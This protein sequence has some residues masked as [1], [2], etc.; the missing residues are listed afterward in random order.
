M[1]LIK[2]K[3]CG[4]TIS[5]AAKKCPNCGSEVES[6]IELRGNLICPECGEKINYITSSCTECG[7][8]FMVTPIRFRTFIMA[9]NPIQVGVEA[10]GQAGQIKA[11]LF[12]KGARG[13]YVYEG[14]FAC[15]FSALRFYVHELGDLKIRSVELTVRC[16]N[17]ENGLAFEIDQVGALFELAKGIYR[18]DVEQTPFESISP[19]ENTILLDA[20]E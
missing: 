8:P 11:V 9:G 15:S 14:A 3:N 10:L 20:S 18:I 6:N 5:S 12:G 16:S 1:A 13:S 7:F 2:C 19:D 4:K 17:N